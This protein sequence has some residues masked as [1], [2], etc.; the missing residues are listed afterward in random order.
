MDRLKRQRSKQFTI[1]VGVKTRSLTF[2][3]DNDATIDEIKGPK[4]FRSQAIQ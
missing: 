2:E 3:L 1:A 4:C